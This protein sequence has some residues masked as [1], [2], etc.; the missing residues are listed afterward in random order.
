[1]NVISV[2]LSCQVAYGELKSLWDASLS[3]CEFGTVRD[4]FA[5]PTD[6]YRSR[7]IL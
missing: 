7:K 4:G 1:M 6:P 5:I 3:F 2:E